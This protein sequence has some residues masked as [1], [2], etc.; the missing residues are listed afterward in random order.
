VLRHVDAG[1]PLADAAAEAIGL[2]VPMN[3]PAD[4]ETGA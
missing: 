1:Y 3:S 4:T 2:Q